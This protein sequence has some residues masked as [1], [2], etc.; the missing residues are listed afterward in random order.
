MSSRTFGNALQYYF[1]SRFRRHSALRKKRI[2]ELKTFA[3]AENYVRSVREKIKKSLTLPAE[4]IDLDPQITDK[5]TFPG[6]VMEKLFFKSRPGFTV[7]GNFYLPADAGNEKLPTVLWLSGHTYGGKNSSMYQHF[8]RSLAMRGFAVLMVDP[9]GQG[10]RRQF[11]AAMAP[12]EQHTIMGKQL[13]LIGEDLFSWRIFD[14]IRSMDYLLTRP[15]VDADRIAICGESGGGTLT[16]WMAAVEDRACCFVPSSAVTTWLHNVENE[17]AIDIEQVPP[18]AAGRGLDFGDFL[19]AAA[20]KPM[21]LLGGDKDFFDPRGFHE[22]KDE[23][24]KIY[25]LLGHPEY[26]DYMMGEDHHGI[27][28]PLREKGYE[29][30][31]NLMGVP[32][33]QKDEGEV[34]VNIEEE[35]LAATPGG[36]VHNLPGEK[37]FYEYIAERVEQLKAKRKKLSPEVLRSRLKTMLGL[38]LPAEAPHYRVLPHRYYPDGTEFQNYTRF[39]LETEP[40]DVMCVLKRL[41]RKTLYYNFEAVQG[42]TT[43]YIPHVDSVDELKVRNPADG[44]ALYALDSRGVGECTST[45]NDLFPGHD[46]YYYY[47]ISYH[48]PSLHLLFGEEMTA[49]RVYD[50]LSALTLIAPAS[51]TGK[52]VLEAKGHGCIDAILAALFSSQVSELRLESLPMSW[53]EIAKHPCPAHKDS[54]FAILPRK[55]LSLTD[56]PELLSAV[57][58]SGILVSYK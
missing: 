1:I 12:T 51:S 37:Y 2:A 15:E 8:C 56:I 58:E 57:H 23:L 7:T 19:I 25:T 9:I 45:A 28:Q 24:K 6:F 40:G 17:V 33:P 13:H 42:T 20:P 26:P 29:F 54:P 3:D 18:G 55:I 46:R 30:L 47:G 11:S 34:P 36:N 39:G 35:F 32:N 41:N 53:E 16:T 10:E 14:A 5:V 22:I 31:C 27:Y 44:D 52:V 48:F 43:L 50:I 49:K 4:K 38:T 21:L